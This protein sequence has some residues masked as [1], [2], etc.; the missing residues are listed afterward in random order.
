MLHGK[1]PG[2]VPHFLGRALLCEEIIAHL[3]KGHDRLV[4]ITGPPGYGKSSVA[5]SVG[6]EMMEQYGYHVY[7]VSTR[8]TSSVDSV[9]FQLLY[10][11]GVVSGDDP[12]SQAHHYLETSHQDILLILDNAEDLLID[13]LKPSFLKF[14]RLTGE[15]APHVRTVVTS[16]VALKFIS[17]NMKNVSLPG[18]NETEAAQLIRIFSP[19]EISNSHAETLGRLC[20]GI[21]LL[22]RAVAS[23]LETN[24]DP[25]LLINEFDR[26][27]G[28]ALHSLALAGMPPESDM[29]PCLKICFERL[30]FELQCHLVA[31][32]VFPSSFKIV[33]TSCV[34]QGMSDLQR[35]LIITQLVDN[36]F[37][38]PDTEGR[39]FYAVHR[40]VQI[41]CKEL[42]K[43]NEKLKNCHQNASNHFNLYFLTILR[44]LN[45]KFYGPCEELKEV[46]IAF[47][48]KKNNIF[49]ALENSIRE[50]KLLRHAADLLNSSFKFFTVRLSSNEFRRLYRSLLESF[51]DSD[52]KKRYSHCLVSLA[53]HQFWVMCSCRRPCPKATKL[54][55]EAF[56]VQKALGHTK[57]EQYAECLSKL[58][59]AYAFD[60]GLAD[61]VIMAD[62]AKTIVDELECN[63]L[64]K[65]SIVN[66]YAGEFNGGVGG[67][68]YKVLSN[69]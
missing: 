67:V 31:L 8:G 45:E 48:C 21:P 42:T 55:K 15:M 65:L 57:S 29:Y 44:D 58:A 56:E 39:S 62:E 61:S 47:E 9:A 17:F 40:I 33:D 1:L 49:R 24:V 37:V 6:H 4:T 18:L 43:E 20:K 50:K 14:I 30:T 53:F 51:K 10:S 27:P 22:I 36:S 66:D 46:L 54:F 12:V 28:T 63:S 11:M 19:Q 41:F 13:E 26:S 5:I 34:L 32:S 38:R 69:L 59:R 64:T 3:H 7:Y 35:Q 68:L 16:R 23:L 60:G 25:E 2:K 52:D